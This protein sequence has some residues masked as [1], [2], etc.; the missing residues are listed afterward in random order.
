MDG[1]EGVEGF[2]E[3]PI[4]LQP[5]GVEAY[6]GELSIDLPKSSQTLAAKQGAELLG[7]G[8]AVPLV[9][10]DPPEEVGGIS[11]NKGEDLREGPADEGLL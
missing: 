5:R 8:Q 4:G 6:P 1:R 7:W 9:E 3:S 11:G 2:A 10:D